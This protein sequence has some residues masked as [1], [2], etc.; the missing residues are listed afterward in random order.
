MMISQSA[1]YQGQF[2][3]E[4]I[5]EWKTWFM[6]IVKESQTFFTSWK[7][8]FLT[9]FGF[10]ALKQEETYVKDEKSE[11][12]ISRRCM[13]NASVFLFFFSMYSKKNTSP[14]HGCKY[15]TSQGEG[16]SKYASRIS[17]EYECNEDD[18]LI[19]YSF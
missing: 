8:R 3:N 19:G 17:T 6:Y 10:S 12:K 2:M 9:F 5:S 18:E 7:M 14:L 13:R 16:C 15:W 11:P 4:T 1:F